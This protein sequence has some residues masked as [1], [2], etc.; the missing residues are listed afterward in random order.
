MYAGGTILNWAGGNAEIERIEAVASRETVEVGTWDTS[1]EELRDDPDVEE[2]IVAIDSDPP[3]A[4]FVRSS[5]PG[6]PPVDDYVEQVRELA[7]DDS[8][9]RAPAAAPKTPPEVRTKDEIP[10]S[11]R[12]PRAV[13][14]SSLVP[15]AP[16]KPSMLPWAMLLL[17]LGVAVAVY[18]MAAGKVAEPAPVLVSAGDEEPEVPLTPDTERVPI[19]PTVPAPPPPMQP[20]VPAPPPAHVPAPAP[21]PAPATEPVPDPKAINAQTGVADTYEAHLALGRQLKRGSRAVAAYR[22][23]IELNPEGGE[24]L[25]ELGRLLLGRQRTREAASLAQRATAVDPTNALGWITLGAARQMRGD[26]EGARQAYQT[27]A[28]LGTGPY[29]KECRAMLR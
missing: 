28:K 17:G 24:A 22:R 14:P 23:A 26:R 21:E 18:F 20:T 11:L 6:A 13:R 25:A 3:P 12:A 27:C 16:A 4:P 8:E 1:L 2:A 9:L 10:P 7:S 29:V 19:P 5:P 15:A